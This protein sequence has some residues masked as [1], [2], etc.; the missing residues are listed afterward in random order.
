ML[1]GRGL[2]CLCEH[3]ARVSVSAFCAARD[4]LEMRMD[5][6][7]MSSTWIFKN[8]IAASWDQ[9]S[10]GRHILFGVEEWIFRERSPFQD[11]AIVRVPSFGK[12]L[13]LDSNPQF[14]ELDEFAYHESVA[15]PP[16]LFHEAPRRVL[17][18]GGGDGLV[19]REVLRDP[20]VEEIVM[21]EI[22]GLV[23]DACR[24]HLRE[25]HRGSFDN[26]RAT[27]LVRDVLS[28]LESDPG[29]FD[30]ILVDLIDGYGPGALNLYDRALPLTNNA[31]A[32]GGIV[33]GFGDFSL[34]RLPAR[35]IH[36]RLTQLFDHV[37]VHRASLETF[38]GE[39]GFLLA[40]HDVDFTAVARE[41]LLERAAALEGE[42]AWLV[43]QQFPACFVLPATLEKRL[44]EPTLDSELD[45]DAF[46]WVFPEDA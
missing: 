15:L 27:V 13:F 31:L 12:G 4:E 37:A 2:F 40:S 44:R 38:S 19:L 28:Y 17:I 6:V 39:Y 43:P 30:V 5:G 22:D 46:G 32:P 34:P 8:W 7:P 29:T 24:T 21:V 33:G 23:I 18:E 26:P 11:V 1:D 35:A 10:P 25:L 42:L 9:L 3:F 36:Q 16:L 20:R 14:L 45:E 41:Q